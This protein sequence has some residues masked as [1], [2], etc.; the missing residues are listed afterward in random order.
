MKIMDLKHHISFLKG[1]TWRVVATADTILL[2]FIYT[3]HIGNSLKIGFI[4]VFTKIILFYFHERIW[5]RIKWGTNIREI[6]NLE[7]RPC[8]D[9]ETR[10]LLEIQEEHYR[11]FIKGVSW[12][13]F[14]TLDTIIIASAL[15]FSLTIIGLLFSAHFIFHDAITWKQM[16]GTCVII[17]GVILINL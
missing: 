16:V 9:D 17:V 11:S 15:F 7:N 13:F 6:V 5:I 4:E 10:N 2:S 3:G 14:G 8:I 12:R 1:I